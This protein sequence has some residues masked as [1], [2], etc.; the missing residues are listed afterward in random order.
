MMFNIEND[1]LPENCLPTQARGAGGSIKPGVKRSETPGLQT[2]RDRAR[3]A[4]DSPVIH[5]T[6]RLSP[7]SQAL[8]FLLRRSWG[9]A[10]LH[11]RLYTV[12]TLRGLNASFSILVKRSFSLSHNS[13]LTPPQDQRQAE[14][15][16]TFHGPNLCLYSV[17]CQYRE[18]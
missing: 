3:G 10:S 1:P 18:R 4:R 8:P 13:R 11:S 7:A 14:A 9:C 12:A 2:G 16:R 5:S 17:E 6:K 15:Y